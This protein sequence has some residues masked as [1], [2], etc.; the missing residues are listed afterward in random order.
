[1]SNLGYLVRIKYVPSLALILA[2]QRSP[3]A[4]SPGKN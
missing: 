3:R 2:R 4:K 1:M